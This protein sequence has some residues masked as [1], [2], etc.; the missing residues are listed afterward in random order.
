MVLFL[1]LVGCEN[2]EDPPAV[3]TPSETPTEAPTP[4]E[5]PVPDLL[6]DV[7]IRDLYEEAG[8]NL[9]RYDH[10]YKGEWYLVEGNVDFMSNY[11]VVVDAGYG[12]R[13]YY[14]DVRAILTDLPHSD[15]IPLN[16]GDVIA[17]SCQVG[18]VVGYGVYM[19]N[20]SLETVTLPTPSEFG[21]TPTPKPTATPDMSGPT[22]TEAMI[23]EPTP[24]EAMM[25]PTATEAMMEP[26]ATEAMMEPTATEAMIAMMEPTATEAMMGPTAT[27]AMMEPTATEAMMEPTATE[28]M[29]EPT[30]TEAMMGPT[31]TEAMMEP[32]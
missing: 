28:A 29:M 25:E 7:T 13:G 27:E 6:Q 26:T 3:L 5:T 23:S 15:Q 18:E 14:G 12:E 19:E 24:T 17:A 11:Q 21:P 20:C 16:S 9:A 31:A 8:T 2:A 10:M 30:A 22:P 4:T 32:R 1:V